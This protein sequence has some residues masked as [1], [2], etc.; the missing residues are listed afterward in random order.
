MK[1]MSN[2]VA[3]YEE[4]FTQNLRRYASMHQRIIVCT[5]RYN[6]KYPRVFKGCRGEPACSPFLS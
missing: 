1:K 2:Y 4:R 6:Y 3:V 5:L